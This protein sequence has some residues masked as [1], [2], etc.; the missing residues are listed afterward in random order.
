[1]TYYWLNDQA[2]FKRV[3]K[4]HLNLGEIVPLPKKK[5]WQYLENYH[6]KM[7]KRDYLSNPKIIQTQF[8]V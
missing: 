5:N 6:L 3:L 2:N 8:N 1:M 4:S 7:K